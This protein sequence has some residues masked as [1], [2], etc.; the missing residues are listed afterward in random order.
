MAWRNGTTFVARLLQAYEILP[1]QG[2]T[3]PIQIA[4]QDDLIR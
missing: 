3:T 4:F 1:E 2:A